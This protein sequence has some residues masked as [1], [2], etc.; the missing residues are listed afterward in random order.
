MNHQL[1]R[2]IARA[3]ETRKRIVVPQLGAFV[4][5]VP[6]VEVVF[7]E[8]FKRDDGVL[9][10][11]L[12]E[13]GMGDIEAAGAVDRFVFELRHAVA[14]NRVHV[15][16]GLGVFAAGPNGTIA[17]RFLPD[18]TAVPPADRPETAAAPVPERRTEPAPVP[19]SAEPVREQ[20]AAVAEGAEKRDEK[21]ASGTIGNAI[22]SRPRTIDPSVKGL[23]YGKTIKNTDAYTYVNAGGARRRPDT[24]ILLAIAAVVLAAGALLYGYF[25]D[26]KKEA[27]EQEQQDESRLP[28]ASEAP[29]ASE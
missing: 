9:R 7:T 6:G 27:W 15:A 12:L 24:F 22:P 19:E 3:L 5:K 4:V 23:R 14:E 25:S 17:F 10:E 16:E 28:E 8:M 11:L 20:A 1:S 29:A 26:R 13:A 2:I 21:P 18:A